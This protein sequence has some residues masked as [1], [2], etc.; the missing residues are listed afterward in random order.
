MR[1][2]SARIASLLIL[3]GLALCA[4]QAR[5]NPVF[6]WEDLY[7]GGA[8]QPD[9]GTVATTDEEGNLVVAGQSTGPAGSVDYLIRKLRRET[10]ETMWTRRVPSIDGNSMVVGGMV[11][12]GAGDLLVGGTREGCYG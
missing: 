9:A 7:D 1:Q 2:F 12:D 6:E 3:A 8:L 11:W 4:L 10:G 5:A